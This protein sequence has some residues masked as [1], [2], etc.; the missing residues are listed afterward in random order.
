MTIPFAFAMGA[1]IS[2]NLDDAWMASVRRWTLIAWFFLSLGLTLGMLWAYEELGWG[3]FWAWDPVEN[4]GFLPWLTATAFFHSV[5]VQ[6][7]RRMMK[8]WNFTLVI[9]TFVLTIIGTSLTRSGIVQ[10]VHAF[11]QDSTLAWMFGGFLILTLVV[12]FGFLIAR[13]N[14][15]ASPRPAGV[16]VQPGVRIS[17]EQLDF[18]PVRPRHLVFHPVPNLDRVDLGHPGGFGPAKFNEFM[19]P[20]GLVLLFLTGVGPLIAWRRASVSHMRHQFAYPTAAALAALVASVGG[21]WS[22]WESVICFVLCAFTFATIVQEFWR[23]AA[24]RRR[25]TNESLGLSLVGLLIKGRRR[26]GGYIVHVGMVL[27]FFGFA[28]QGFVLEKE[29]QM[30]P[31]SEASI[32]RYTLK[33]NGL[34]HQEDGEKRPSGR[35]SP[36]TVRTSTDPSAIALVLQEPP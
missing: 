25:N 17:A 5:M 18:R 12:S 21:L 36:W 31:G 6:E 14:R 35:N 24:I 15:T 33:Y 23:G 20:I 8:M 2:G 4:A 19:V 7:R 26:Y 11:G 3:G 16:R 22:A 32:G 13:S 27:M 29:W 1:L 34:Q 28:G 9:L 30:T 10:S